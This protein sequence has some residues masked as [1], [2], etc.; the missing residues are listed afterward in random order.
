MWTQ[1][2]LDKLDSV[3]NFQLKVG[4]GIKKVTNWTSV[5]LFMNEQVVK[6]QKYGHKEFHY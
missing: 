4:I 1:N 3:K 2:E 6:D 5:T